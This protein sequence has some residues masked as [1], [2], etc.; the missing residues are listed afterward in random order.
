LLLVVL[1]SYSESPHYVK[2]PDSYTTIVAVCPSSSCAQ[3]GGLI[4]VLPQNEVYRTTQPHNEV[5]K[6][7]PLHNEVYKNILPQNEVFKSVGLYIEMNTLILSQNQIVN[8]NCQLF[9]KVNISMVNFRVKSFKIL[10]STLM[11]GVEKLCWSMRILLESLQ[12][13]QKMYIWSLSE[14][15]VSIQF[16]CRLIGLLLKQFLFRKH[17]FALYL[18]RVYHD[19]QSFHFWPLNIFSSY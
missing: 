15:Q 10:T 8:I 4:L 14:N 1:S 13:V 11:H 17:D 7:T 6:T 9:H 5:Y 12:H 2:P 18:H 16:R 19:Y 3:L